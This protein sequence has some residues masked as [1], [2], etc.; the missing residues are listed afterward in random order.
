MKDRKPYPVW[1]QPEN[2][3]GVD[4]YRATLPARMTGGRVIDSL[5][6]LN[7]SGRTENLN[8]LDHEQCKRIA[9]LPEVTLL[10]LGS[11]TVLQLFS[12]LGLYT[13]GG[14]FSYGTGR[15]HWINDPSSTPRRGRAHFDRNR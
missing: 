1:L 5:Q 11:P 9:A 6:I 15:I 8:L 2:G 7:G 13:S 14:A 4:Y 12:G 10:G 3:P